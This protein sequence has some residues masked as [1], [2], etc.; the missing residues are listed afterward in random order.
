[1]KVARCEDGTVRWMWQNLEVE[2]SICL[3][4]CGCCMGMRTVA[5][6]E[7]SLRQQYSSLVAIAG[8][9]LMFNISAKSHTVI[10][11]S[12][13]MTALAR[14]MWSS[15]TRRWRAPW[16]SFF[17]HTCSSGFQ[18]FYPLSNFPFLQLTLPFCVKILRC[19]SVGFTPSAKINLFHGK[20]LKVGAIVQ[21]S[22][23]VYTD[24]AS[25]RLTMECCAMHVQTDDNTVTIDYNPSAVIDFVTR[26][27]L[28]LPL[29]I[30][31]PY[32]LI[33]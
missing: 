23:H 19:T 33:F 30:D 14:S 21:Q 10:R 29:L 16:S 8:F 25:A 26:S 27:I 3:S 7:N 22:V 1:M 13:W 4:C 6:Q 28:K 17:R 9:R 12:S 31:L 2:A 5:V 20:L 24:T 15:G 32:Y 18:R 11:Q